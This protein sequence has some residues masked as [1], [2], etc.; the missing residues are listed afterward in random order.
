MS[1][2]PTPSPLLFSVSDEALHEATGRTH[3][4]WF[5][6]LDSWGAQEKEHGPTAAWLVEEHSMD[7]WWA[8]TV[9]I[10]Y[11]RARGLRPKGGHR[12]GTYDANASKTVAVS[13]GGLY[14]AIVDPAQRARWLPEA[15]LAQR[16]AQPNRSVRFD[17]GDGTT[18]VHFYLA[19]KSAEKS[20][21]SLQHVRLPDA[22]SAEVKKVFW[23]ERLGALKQLLEG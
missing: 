2:D 4:E 7:R 6:L 11:E 21:V 1:V 20:Q 12:D 14:Q 3:E 8:Q 16:T 13:V 18:R 10:D 23:R 15:P 17:W 19:E 22:E 9:T 5:A